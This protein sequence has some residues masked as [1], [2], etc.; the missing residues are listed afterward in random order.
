MLF[1]RAFSCIGDEMRRTK[2]LVCICMCVRVSCCVVCVIAGF[3]EIIIRFQNKILS[4]KNVIATV[5]A[6]RQSLNCKFCRM[7]VDFTT[8]A[9]V[10]VA[11][12]ILHT[13]DL[14]NSP[15]QKFCTSKLNFSSSSSCCTILLRDYNI[16]HSIV[17]LCA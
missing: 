10:T 6:T 9:A 11:L 4:S 7:H 13:Y 3:C 2:F 15:S 17:W 14:F 8:A 16:M 1:P 12:P 5:I